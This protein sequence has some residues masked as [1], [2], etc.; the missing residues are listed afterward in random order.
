MKKLDITKIAQMEFNISEIYKI[1]RWHHYSMSWGLNSPSMY[2]DK[3]LIFKVQ[4]FVHRGLVFLSL[5]YDDTFTITLTKINKTVVKTIKWVY[6][7][8]LIHTLDENI[9]KKVSDEEYKELVENTLVNNPN[10]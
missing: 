5:A 4:G 3:I 9:E 7:D 10:I 2:K 8:E 1:I 6:I